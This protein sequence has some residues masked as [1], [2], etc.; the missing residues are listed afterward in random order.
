MKSRNRFYFGMLIAV[1]LTVIIWAS[2]GML[3]VGR[4]EE[5]YSVSVIV[6]NSSSDRWTSL[7]QG[8]E[9]AARDYNIDLNYVSTGSFR[10]FDEECDAIDRELGNG[11]QGVIVQMVTSESGE[12]IDRVSTQAS[13]VLLE[14]DVKPEDLYTLVGPDNAGMGEAVAGAV[15]EDFGATLSGKRIGILSGNQKQIAMQQR[16]AGVSE[17]LENA[18]AVIAWSIEGT[19]DGSKEMFYQ[20]VQ[21]EPVDILIALGNDELEFLVDYVSMQTEQPE[22]CLLYG[23]GGSEKTV[24]YLDKGVIG[25]LVVPNEFNMGYLSMETIAKQL[26]YHMGESGSSRVDYLVVNRT[27]LYDEDNQKVLFPIVQ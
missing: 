3:N 5:S 13:V 1:V 17:N 2:Y 25:A 20:K 22:D 11:A 14:T 9:Q 24:Y 21:Q 15:K 26:I 18:G 7:R 12:E 16:L 8:L 19:S 6:E 27:N 4:E 23:I 10:N